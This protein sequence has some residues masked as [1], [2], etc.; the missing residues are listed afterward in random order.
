[1]KLALALVIEVQ[2]NNNSP[3]HKPDDKVRKVNREFGW[4]EIFRA[5]YKTWKLFNWKFKSNGE[6]MLDIWPVPEDGVTAI[7]AWSQLSKYWLHIHKKGWFRMGKI[8][9]IH[10]VSKG[11]V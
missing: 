3:N 9:F 4:I 1:M 11:N 10:G 5:N 7:C 6:A 8:S 2:K